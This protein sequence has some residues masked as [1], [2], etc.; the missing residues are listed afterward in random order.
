MSH[1][2]TTVKVI[3]QKSQEALQLLM[4]TMYQNSEGTR[5]S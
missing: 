3:S 2:D 1:V 5:N 4:M